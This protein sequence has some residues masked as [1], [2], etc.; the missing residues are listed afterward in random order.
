MKLV[1]FVGYSWLVSGVGIACYVAYSFI[2]LAN[3]PYFRVSSGAF[4]ATCIG[5]VFA[6]I[7]CYAGAALIANLRG[8]K[9][10]TITV[11]VLAFIYGLMFF[12]LGG[13]HDRPVSYAMVVLV[14]T[15]LPI[16]SVV[17]LAKAP[18]QSPENDA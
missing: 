2:K 5:A 1:Q 7:V 8:K 12:F 10:L 13:V 6:F 18:N 4:K 3:S 11:S 17:A 9:F 15:V 16:L 14:L